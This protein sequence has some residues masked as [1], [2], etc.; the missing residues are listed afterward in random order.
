VLC[1]LACSPMAP[2]IALQSVLVA[3]LTAPAMLAESF[4]WAAT[5]LLGGV[6]IGIAAGGA[7]VDGHAPFW[8]MLAAALAALAA[9][10][11]TALALARPDGAPG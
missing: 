7:I 2:V 3:R 9:A 5:A 8:A 11:V 1:V 6:S 10:L 4:T